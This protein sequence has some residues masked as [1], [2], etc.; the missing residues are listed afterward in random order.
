VALRHSPPADVKRRRKAN[1]STLWLAGLLIAVIS[2]I[3]LVNLLA[4]LFGTAFM[5]HI[6]KQ[7]SSHA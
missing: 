2:M 3:P 4:P 5:V 6:H 7:L 1:R